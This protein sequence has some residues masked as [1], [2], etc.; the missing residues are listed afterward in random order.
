MKRIWT[1][2][3][4]A[5]L[6]PYVVTLVWSGSIRGEQKPQMVISGK[7]ILLDGDQSGYVDAEEYLIGMT[8]RQMPPDYGPEALKAQAVIART[9]LYKK[10]GDSDEIKESELGITYIEESGLE[11]LWGSEK[12]VEYYK[13][14]EEAV[15]AT[16]GTVMMYEDDEI[17][18]LYHRASAGMTRAGDEHHPYLECVESRRDVEADNYL[19]VLNWSAESVASQLKELGE[20]PELT[21]AQLPESIQMIEKD[22]AG[23]VGKIQIGNH[24]YTGEEIAKAL[25]LPSSC[26]TLENYEGQIRAVCKGIGHGYGLS[27]YGAKTMGEEGYTWEDILNYYYKNIVLISS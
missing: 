6:I 16:A 8:G 5:L 25:S 13:N 21:A 23:Y 2:C 10:M 17:D 20:D 7:R 18:A 24:I 14:I 19:S 3:L 26:F 4:L 15:K 9:Y 12:F 27:Q 11:K 22:N 1:G